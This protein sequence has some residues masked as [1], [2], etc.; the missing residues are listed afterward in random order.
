MRRW[1]SRF[2]CASLGARSSHSSLSNILA[3]SRVARFAAVALTATL[4]LL[5]IGT[6]PAYTAVARITISPLS[7]SFPKQEVDTTSASKNVTLT[8]PNSFA[9]QIDSVM[10]SAGE[11]SVSRDGCSGVRLAP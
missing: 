8:N 2:A 3:L 7:L 11:F 9:L 1:T 6:A 4:I 10:A 5:S